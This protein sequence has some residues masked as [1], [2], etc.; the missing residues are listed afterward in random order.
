MSKMKKCPY[1]SSG[2]AYWCNEDCKECPIPLEFEENKRWNKEHEVD[3]K[4]S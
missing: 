4:C 1:N 2:K 3:Q